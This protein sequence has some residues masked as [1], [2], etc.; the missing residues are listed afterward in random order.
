ML[1]YACTQNIQLLFN[2]TV[3]IK[4]KYLDCTKYLGFQ[5]FLDIDLQ[6]CWNEWLVD[7]IFRGWLN[8]HRLKLSWVSHI[9]KLKVECGTY[10]CMLIDLFIQLWLFE[11]YN[12]HSSLGYSRSVAHYKVT[13]AAQNESTKSIGE[14]MKHLSHSTLHRA[15]V[16]PNRTID[17]PWLPTQL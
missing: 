12:Y 6:F 14:F 10:R 15:L 11:A 8:D 16:D 1:Y 2:F 9:R 4:I 5:T 17:T 13:R 3:K 7:A